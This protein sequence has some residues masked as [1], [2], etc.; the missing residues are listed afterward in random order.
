MEEIG[1]LLFIFALILLNGAF[2]A[3]E[4]SIA[5]VRKTQVAR[6]AEGKDPTARKNEVKAA[7]LLLKILDD[8]NNY[9]SAC[10][11]G[12]TIASLVIGVIAEA[13]IEEMITPLVKMLPLPIEPHMISIV[14]AILIITFFHVILGEVVPKTIALVD[15]ENTGLK[16][17]YFLVGL[18]AIFKFPVHL[19][20]K[21]AE[22]CL[23]VMGIEPI[24]GEVVHSEDEL[25][26]IVSTSQ[27][28]GIIEEEEEEMI[29]N[30]FAFND[31]VAKDIMTPRTDM[32]CLK[33]D[34]SIAE[35]TSEILKAGYSRFPIFKER[36]DNITGY[37]TVKDVL[38]AHQ[39]KQ[40]KKLLKSIV[41]KAIKVSDGIFVIDLMHEMQNKK[42]QLAI[43]IDEYG[44]TSGLVT[45][46]DIVE[47]IFGEIHDEKE[48][49]KEPI[50]QIKDREYLI[51]GLVNLKEIN[52]ELGTEFESEHYDTIG[53]LV[54][55]LI[56][57]DPKPGDMVEYQDFKL[58]VE[59]HENQRVREVRLIA[60]LTKQS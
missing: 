44:G 37:V 52:E 15:P 18:Y 36:L 46:E 21:C 34:L 41:N 11:V 57:S 59:K 17:T 13:Q 3:G 20:N 50:Q 16:L 42:K 35:A 48:P 40:E 10:Q 23:R 8:L 29:H 60:K 25:K 55:G 14:L 28:E 49:A 31:T 54:Y 43:L 19:L 2:V 22:I 30:V 9:I 5:R 51:D 24:F 1:S 45:S 12:I 58:I 47:E 39:E 33:E 7:K 53:G 32:F 6:I 27:E 56:G 38:L 4:F 26:M